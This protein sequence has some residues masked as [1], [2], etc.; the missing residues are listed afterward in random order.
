MFKFHSE[1][2]RKLYLEIQDKARSCLMQHFGH[3]MSWLRSGYTRTP[4]WFSRGSVFFFLNRGLLDWKTTLVSIMTCL[5][6]LLECFSLSQY[7]TSVHILPFGVNSRFMTCLKPAF[8]F[9]SSPGDIITAGDFFQN[10]EK[11]KL[12]RARLVLSKLA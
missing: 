6:D 4:Y 11:Y 12:A 5:L 7:S 10:H 2:Y 1:N 8:P 3:S 9:F